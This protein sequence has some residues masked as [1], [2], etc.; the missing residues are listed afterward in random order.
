[1]MIEDDPDL[2][3][4]LEYLDSLVPESFYDEETLSFQAIYIRAIDRGLGDQIAAIF[5]KEAQ[6]LERL[7]LIGQTQ[8]D[9]ESTRRT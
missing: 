4:A 9:D 7:G 5:E 1:M 6:R 2:Y 3:A 8:H